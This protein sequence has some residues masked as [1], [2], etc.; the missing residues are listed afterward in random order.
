M[1]AFICIEVNI[2]ILYFCIKYKKDLFHPV[3]L[4]NLMWLGVHTLNMILG[5][6]SDEHT[7]LILLLPALCFSV[8]FFIA[9]T[10]KLSPKRNA[11]ALMKQENIYPS[12]SMNRYVSAS[13]LLG[14]GIVFICYTYSYISKLPEFIS[15][16]N[17][18]LSFRQ[19]QW[20]YN[21]NDKFVFKYTSTVA[22]LLPSVL[23][24]SAQKSKKRIDYAQFVCS[25]VIA[26]VWSILRT[27]RTS[28]FQVV[29]IM[30][31]SQLLLME[32]GNETQRNKTEELK[33]RKKKLIIFVL[34]VLFILAVFIVVAFKKMGSAY[35]DVSGFEFILRSLANYT[36]LSSAA[37]V[38]WYKNGVE[39]TYGAGSFRFI[40]AVLSKLG[41]IKA[42]PMANSGGLFIVYEGMSTNALTV[43]RTYIEDF[44]VVYM[45]AILAVFG[46]IHGTVYRKA[47]TSHGAKKSRYA[48]INAMLDIPLFFQIL[49][50]QYL[51]VL[52]GWIQYVF[53]ISL[54]TFPL[55]WST[56]LAL[57]E[58]VTRV[59]CGAAKSAASRFERFFNQFLE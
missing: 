52:S 6:N 37:F 2:A 30:V 19:I 14:V 31:M 57:K 23:L 54:F 4:L 47:C 42:Q 18:W 11:D 55:F 50:N 33:I 1:A 44:G 39:Y 56:N 59:L 8:G 5:W 48:L 22:F 21:I 45:G 40:I 38:E 36:N 43:A 51:N 13:L 20:K 9:E 29:I 25:L 10:L 3:C 26:V 16:G 41:I 34:A 46:F 58:N 17:V 32:N 27:S 15:N 49:T 24:I 7:Y 12:H 35:G 28:T 53:W